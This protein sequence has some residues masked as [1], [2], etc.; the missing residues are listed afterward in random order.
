MNSGEKTALEDGYDAG[1]PG[2][3]FNRGSYS[4][5]TVLFSPKTS[6]TG[7]ALADHCP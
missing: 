3:V 2:S 1:N 6:L 7:F 5:R 4:S